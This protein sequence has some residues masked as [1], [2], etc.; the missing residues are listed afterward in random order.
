MKMKEGTKII[1]QLNFFHTL[2][3]QLT[4]MNVKIDNEDKADNLL[5]TLHE[6]WGQVVSSII[7][8][9]IDT[10]EFDNVAGAL[11]S[12]ELRKKYSFETSS[13]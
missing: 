9:T 5:C 10:L 8:G 6:S 1:K 13:P 3:F 12:E 4:S 11:F 7:L 2:I